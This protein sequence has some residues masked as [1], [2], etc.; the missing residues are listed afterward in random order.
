MINLE[1]NKEGI[2]FKVRA[3]EEDCKIVKDIIIGLSV[4]GDRD[5]GLRLCLEESIAN[6]IRHGNNYSGKIKINFMDCEEY[7]RVRIED[8]GKGFDWANV[9]DPCANENL[10]KPGG[11]GIKLMRTY[12]D[13]VEYNQKGNCVTF[14]FYKNGRH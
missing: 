11:R 6:A 4:T 14:D 5:F 8:S 9:S 12:A 13:S 3:N 10:E 2:E 7:I 1:K